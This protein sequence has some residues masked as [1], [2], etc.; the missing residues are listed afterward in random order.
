MYRRLLRDSRLFLVAC[1]VWFVCGSAAAAD[2]PSVSLQCKNESLAKVLTRLDQQSDFFL[3]FRP[4]DVRDE[5]LV[6]LQMKSQPLDK[7]LDVLLSP[8]GLAYKVQGK[9]I[10]IVRVPKREA[11]AVKAAEERLIKGRVVDEQGQPV[12]GASVLLKGKNKGALTDLD[13]AFQLQA[14]SADVLQISFVGYK[15]QDVAVG[16]QTM[17]QVRLQPDVEQLEEVVVVGYGTQKRE[18]LTSSVTQVSAKDLNAGAVMDIASMVQGKVA[19]LSVVNNAGS[20]PNATAQMQIRGI[21]TIRAGNSPLI[22]IDGVYSNISDLNSLSPDDIASFN[23]LKDASSAAIYGTR[24]SNGVILVETKRGNTDRQLIEFNSSVST[25]SP[26]NRINVMGADQ[27]LTILEKYV[28]SAYNND[29]GFSTDWFD[30]LTQAP[31]NQYYNLAFSGGTDKTQYRASVGY[32]DANGMVI[33]TYNKAVNFRMNL[34]QR[35]FKNR[36]QLLTNVSGQRAQKKF[37][38]YGAFEQALQYNPTAPVYRADGTFFE[39][40]GV[41]PS[42]PVALLRQVDD[43]GVDNFLNGSMVAKL[44]LNNYFNLDV[45]GVTSIRDFDGAYYES[46]NSRNSQINKFEGMAQ[47]KA[48]FSIDNLFEALLN[49]EQSFGV[50]Q[51]QAMAGY[52]YQ[53]NHHTWYGMNNKGFLTDGTGADNIGTGTFLPDGRAGMWSGREE[54]ALVS[55]FGR[56]NYSYADKYLLSLSLRREGSTRFGQDNKWGTFPAVSAG[57]NLDK[58]DFVKALPQVST[59]KLRAGYGI[60]GNQGIP[61]YSSIARLGTGGMVFLDGQWVPSYGPSSNANPE[62]QWERNKEANIGVDFGLWD[63]RLSGTVDLYHRLTDNLLDWYD[64]P[65]PSYIYNRIFTNV[66]SMSNQGVELSLTADWVRGKD[67]S[68]STT[69]VYAHNKNR[70]ESLSNKDFKTNRI[71]Y[72]SLPGPGNLGTTMIMEEGLPI[73]TFYGL[74]YKGFDEDGKW[75]FEDVNGDGQ[76]S[77]DDFQYLGNGLPTSTFSI[78][79]RL[80]YKRFDFSFMLR[81]AAGFDILNTKR[82]YYENPQGL[83]YNM[84]ES[85]VGS[86]LKDGMKFSDYYI[87]KGDYLKVDNVTLG[88]TLDA[89]A[90]DWLRDLRIFVT[91]TNLYTFTRYSGLDPEVGSSTGDGLTPGYDARSYYPRSRSFLL[92]LNVKF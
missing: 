90:I 23:V 65:M 44:N 12:P 29:F 75:V 92:G 57:W 13:G 17:F 82:I 14:T 2:F 54:S 64:A 88:Y 50:H 80:N 48:D 84:L 37:T 9:Q 15:T 60:T 70:L 55:F 45:K 38:N 8:H 4:E 79:N 81:G 68:W 85:F 51:L 16:N 20:D 25:Q 33:D 7:V 5:Q 53:H 87:E 47:R 30:E 71:L 35:A 22:I 56:A 89:K 3:V 40:P 73:G 27:Y 67:L 72:N 21:G 41:G 26:S 91:T 76:Y 24:G 52:A 58:E 42:N 1:L 10:I 86:P 32:R 77:P 74:K 31:V 34:S 69:F 78:T 46:V 28:H 19:G 49:Y 63:N 6:S 62:L 39:F 59:L 36:L 43:R 83:P 18:Q 61:L 66:G 11:P